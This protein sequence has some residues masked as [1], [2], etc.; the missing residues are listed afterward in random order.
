MDAQT[1]VCLEKP[2]PLAI[3]DATDV[4]A[5]PANQVS[6]ASLAAHQR[7]AKR[8]LSH[9]A[10]P[11]DAEPPDHKDHLAQAETPVEPDPQAEPAVTVNQAEPDP[12]DP[13]APLGAQETTEAQDRPADQP[14]ALHPHPETLD[15][16]EKMEP[17]D[18]QETMAQLDGQARTDVTE[19]REPPDPQE[20]Q[21]MPA[22]TETP[23]LTDNQDP[24]EN[25]VSARNT[26][27]LMVECSSL[28]E[29]DVKET[30]ANS[31]LH[32]VIAIVMQFLNVA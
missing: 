11:V 27:P 10:D 14:S 9:H 8:P 28:T 15:C 1:V 12:K 22:G 30:S 19:T 7:S 4:Q 29:P 32:L 31:S 2:D 6:L 23:E 24:L 13:Q 25:P 18:C 16:Q 21:V 20:P 5:C 3:Q 26:A 17:R